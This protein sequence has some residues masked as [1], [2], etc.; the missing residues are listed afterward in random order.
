[1]RYKKNALT[2]DMEIQDKKCTL[3]V[4]ILVLAR[5]LPILP[6]FLLW[7]MA[8]YFLCHLLLEVC[9]LLF[10]FYRGLQL[11]GCLKSQKMLNSESVLRL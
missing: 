9:N 7:G 4:F 10:D 6:T 1:M 3:L 8:L 5:C 11:R 2:L